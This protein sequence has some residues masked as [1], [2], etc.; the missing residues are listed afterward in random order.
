MSGAEAG[1]REA[2]LTAKNRTRRS[3]HTLASANGMRSGP[4]NLGPQSPSTNSSDASASDAL[5]VCPRIDAV[6]SLLPLVRMH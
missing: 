6:L 2:F 4:A 5:K 1:A 3:L